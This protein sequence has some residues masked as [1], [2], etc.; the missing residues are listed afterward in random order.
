MKRFIE[1][2]LSNHI[3]DIVDNSLINC[4]CQGL[5]SIVF[6]NTD[7]SRIRLFVADENHVLYKNELS[8]L[9]DGGTQ[10]IAFHPHHCD[11]TLHSVFGHI[12]NWLV[13]PASEVGVLPVKKYEYQS[14]INH[15]YGGFSE[16]ESEENHIASLG[17]YEIQ[18][19]Y[20]Q[21][22]KAHQIHTIIVPK[23]TKAAWFIYEGQEWTNYKPVC[24]SVSDLN[25]INMDDL[26]QPM[27]Q[28]KM[29]ELLKSVELI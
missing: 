25:D 24:Y 8:L 7:G 6:H 16:V 12:N 9:R 5:H 14:A 20:S 10:S 27:N 1:H 11:L 2:C 26:Y 15:D 19:G 21:F 29:F 28:K 17:F 22:L 3:Y 13:T 23:G 18:K 4:H